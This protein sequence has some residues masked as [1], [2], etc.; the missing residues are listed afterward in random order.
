MALL[1]KRA[2][3]SLSGAHSNYLN[4][5][6]MKWHADPFHPES[7]PNGFLNL[8]T[9]ENRLMSD[10][11]TAKLASI[12]KYDPES[13]YYFDKRGFAR[14]RQTLASF[15]TARLDA[16]VPLDPDRLI[17]V[18]GAST[19][20]DNFAHVLAD[21]GEVFLGTTP[22]YRRIENNLGERS[23]VDMIPI[24]LKSHSDYQLTVADLEMTLAVAKL[25]GRIVRGIIL[26]NPHNPLGT[27]LSPRIILEVLEFAKRNQ[28]HVVFDEVF[29]LS[30]FEPEIEF[31]SV[32]GLAAILP[33]PERTHF[34]WGFSKDFC[35]S[36]FRC[37]VMYSWSQ[38]VVK[39]LTVLT[40]FH[41]MSAPVQFTL[42]ALLTDE[43]WLDRVY[44]PENLKRL[45]TARDE[46]ASSLR[47]MGLKVLKSVAGFC[48]WVQMGHLKGTT[49]SQ[50]EANDDEAVFF[51][52]LLNEARI[53]IVPG[54]ELLSSEKNWARILFACSAEERREFLVRLKK[55]R[56]EKRK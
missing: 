6:F 15:L 22:C 42:N 40:S 30:V 55:F 19:A 29:A 51:R 18:D 31:C 36:G 25:D 20:L 44:F 4:E 46:M 45:K 33:D 26:M 10:V 5:A 39:A 9:A 49:S 56:E 11:L 52:E 17:V 12:S 23:L 8:G 13:Q 24:T 41:A 38:E 21:A 47:E 35:L 34:Y 16:S 32:A 3:K 50:E 43:E 1:S 14:F 2:A 54:Q 7:N 37:G 53:Y 48:L 27:V 28:L